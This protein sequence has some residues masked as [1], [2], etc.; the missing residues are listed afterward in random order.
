MGLAGFR[1]VLTLKPLNVPA[2]ILQTLAFLICEKYLKVV[3]D[4]EKAILK[5]E[6]D[7]LA[8]DVAKMDF[9]KLDELEKKLSKIQEMSK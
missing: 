9:A 2:E 1:L 4:R 5:A 8:A 7:K 6:V 3:A